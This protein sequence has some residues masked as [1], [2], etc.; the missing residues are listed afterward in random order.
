[1]KSFF[2]FFKESTAVQQA[3]RM[4]LQS[5]GHGGWYDKKGE[6]TFSDIMALV[7]RSI[8]SSKYFSKSENQVDLDKYPEETINTLIYQLSLAA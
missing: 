8:W 2:Q 4:G 3:T 1:M 7:R 5:D 6:L